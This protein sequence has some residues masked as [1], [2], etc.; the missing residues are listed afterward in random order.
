LPNVPVSIAGL[1]V[2][3]PH[4]ANSIIAYKADE[5]RL[6]ESTGR[7]EVTVL[8]VDF[9][10]WSGFRFFDRGIAQSRKRQQSCRT[11]QM[12]AKEFCEM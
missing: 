5:N 12:P 6:P 8:P 1:L 7:A 3:V 10:A 9:S 11:P 2:P 4:W